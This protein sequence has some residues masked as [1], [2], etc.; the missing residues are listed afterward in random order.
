MVRKYPDLIADRANFSDKDNP[1]SW[2]KMLAPLV[3]ILGPIVMLFVAGLDMRFEWSP[4]LPLVLQVAG[5]VIAALGYSLGVW[6]TAVNKFFSSVVR[7]QR[8]RGHSTI[9]SGPYKYVR[10]PGYA[11]GILANFA[12]PLVLDSLWA[13]VPA[14]LVNSVDPIFDGSR[15]NRAFYSEIES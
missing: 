7:I 3:A 13:L 4:N 15:G 10:H 5:L 6:A 14:L 1:K 9:T 12:M 2:D 11:G 8:K